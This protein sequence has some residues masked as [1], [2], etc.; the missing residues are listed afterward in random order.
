M[1][2]QITLSKEE[3]ESAKRWRIDKCDYDSFDRLFKKF[4]KRYDNEKN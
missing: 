4:L 1:K 2:Q 3:R